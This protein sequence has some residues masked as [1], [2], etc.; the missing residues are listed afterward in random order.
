MGW[1]LIAANI[2]TWCV[3]TRM[4]AAQNKLTSDDKDEMRIDDDVLQ[5]IRFHFNAMDIVL[6]IF[7]HGATDSRTSTHDPGCHTSIIPIF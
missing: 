4:V 6:W 5:Q 7:D 3:Q 2:S 1:G